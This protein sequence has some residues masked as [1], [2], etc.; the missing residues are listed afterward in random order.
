M[1]KFLLFLLYQLGLLL[2]L[3]MH[4]LPSPS[5]RTVK[6]NLLNLF[7]LVVLLLYLEY[8]IRVP[9]LFNSHH[10]P[11]PAMVI[12]VLVIIALVFTQI[13]VDFTVKADPQRFLA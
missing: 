11:A 1:R 5:L 3:H 12:H 10:I 8:P 4:L 9:R 2:V 13:K 7:A 6:V